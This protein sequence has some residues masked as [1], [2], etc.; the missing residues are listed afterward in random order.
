MNQITVRIYALVI[1]NKR[2]VLL[3][4]ERIL[5]R[6]I[7]KFPGG[8]L[9]FGEG[10]RQTLEREFMEEMNEKCV[11]KDHFY[12]TDI[13]QKAFGRSHIQMFAVYYSVDFLNEPKHPIH[14]SRFAKEIQPGENSFWWCPISELKPEYFTLESDKIVARKLQTLYTNQA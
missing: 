10:S 1:N 4:D 11:V 3:S 6:P 13:Y 8:G 2:E 9:D 7:T 5:D 12:T 14:H